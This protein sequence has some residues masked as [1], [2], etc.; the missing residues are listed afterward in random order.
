MSSLQA[1]KVR[2]DN[3]VNLLV[4]GST[5]VTLFLLNEAK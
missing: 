3:A 5:G 1:C 4:M 2:R